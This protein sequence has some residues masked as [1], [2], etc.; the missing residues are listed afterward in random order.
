M[1]LTSL[2]CAIREFVSR[3]GGRLLTVLYIYRPYE[4]S[5]KLIFILTKNI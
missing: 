5:N 1:S 4:A 2:L 3:S